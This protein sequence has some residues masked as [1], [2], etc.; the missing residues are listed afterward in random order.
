MSL[1]GAWMLSRWRSGCGQGPGRLFQADGPAIA[2]VRRPSAFVGL[3]ARRCWYAT[4]SV[5]HGQCDVRPAVTFLASKHR[6]VGKG[7]YEKW[8]WK[9]DTRC[10]VAL[11]EWSKFRLSG[12]CRMC[13]QKSVIFMLIVHQNIQRSPR[14]PEKVKGKDQKKKRKLG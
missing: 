1:A 9:S 10:F 8:S 11:E 5:M 13:Y 3:F 4:K 14:S 2:K 6:C 12:G 7:V